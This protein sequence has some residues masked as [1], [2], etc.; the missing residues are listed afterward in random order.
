MR[1]SKVVSHWRGSIRAH[2]RPNAKVLDEFQILLDEVERQIHFAALLQ[3]A[4]LAAAG[5]YRGKAAQAC[6]H[7]RSGR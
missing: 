1:V 2:R 6:P 7:A 4:E 5:R 3:I